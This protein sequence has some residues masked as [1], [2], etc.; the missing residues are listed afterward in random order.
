MT[1]IDPRTGLPVRSDPRAAAR[2]MRPLLKVLPELPLPVIQSALEQIPEQLGSAVIQFEAMHAAERQRATQPGYVPQPLPSHPFE[3]QVLIPVAFLAALLREA[4]A[5]NGLVASWQSEID[6]PDA[7]DVANDPPPA[8]AP[9]VPTPPDP[10][11]PDTGATDRVA[12]LL[13]L[14]TSR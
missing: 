9:G 4:G 5:A 10:G 1:L 7:P 14:V 3:V 2:A 12:G 13:R 8:G 6:A 11:A